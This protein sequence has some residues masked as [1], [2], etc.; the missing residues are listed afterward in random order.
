MSGKW[1]A[2]GDW[3]KGSSSRTAGATRVGMAMPEAVG[4][5]Y[6][7]MK[8]P[9]AHSN[10]GRAGQ[11]GSNSGASPSTSGGRGGGSAGSPVAGGAAR[12]STS[13][14]ASTHSRKAASDATAKSGRGEPPATG[15]RAAEPIYEAA[16]KGPGANAPAGES[17]SRGPSNPNSATAAEQARRVFVADSHGRVNTPGQPPASDQKPNTKPDAKSITGHDQM[18]RVTWGFRNRKS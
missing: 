9:A 12:D 11:S 5:A 7:T 14:S 2:L 17:S 15:W 1:N 4:T 3:A 13:G 16:L 6:S 18:R 8:P 10:T